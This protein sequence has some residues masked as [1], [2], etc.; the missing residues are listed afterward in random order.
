MKDKELRIIKKLP[1]II[2]PEN[3]NEMFIKWY[4]EDLRFQ[5]EI[6]K[7]FERGYIKISNCNINI[8][9]ESINSKYI[10]TMAK[11]YKT[12]Y[13]NIEDAFNEYINLT[14]NTILYFEFKNECL[15][16][17]VYLDNKL[18]N[19]ME[20]SLS[21]IEPNKP[22]PRL[23]DKL[24]EM[25]E[26]NKSFQEMYTYQCFILL[27]CCLWYIATTT[28]TTKYYRQNKVPKFIY[29]KKEI[30]NPKRNKT[31]STPIYDMNKIR[32]VETSGLIKRRKGWTYSHAFKVHGH[33]RHYENGKVIFIEPFI[34]GKGKEEISQI[35]TLNPKEN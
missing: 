14:N 15:Y 8:L 19:T 10:S 2:L 11:Y 34:K 20:L 24:K 27:E 9:K 35:I 28:R 16:I 17:E 1:Q 29:E 13:R 33:Y 3:K 4:N 26:Q 32:K 6:P 12:T 18:F 23:E 21:M 7:V 25:I 31:I 30:I 5:D 22:N